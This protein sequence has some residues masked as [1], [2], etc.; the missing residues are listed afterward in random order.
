MPWK[1]LE[2][3]RRAEADFHNLLGPFT[4]CFL[5]AVVLGSA[6]SVAIL[7]SATRL[8]CLTHRRCARYQLDGSRWAAQAA[9]AAL[10]ALSLLIVLFQLNGRIAG[11]GLALIDGPTAPFEWFS[12]GAAAGAWAL[13]TALFAVEAANGYA[14]ARTWLWRFPVFLTLAAELAK[15]RFVVAFT[16]AH[17]YFFSLFAVSLIA[18]VALAA[19]ALLHAP[20]KDSL[21]LLDPGEA[22]DGAEGYLPLTEDHLR[23]CPEATA[24]LWSSL[25][26]SWMGALMRA[27]FAAPLQFSDIWALP[28]R[29][30][31]E[32]LDQKFRWE[33]GQE[34]VHQRRK[35]PSLVSHTFCVTL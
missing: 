1:T 24:G 15:L 35:Q 17:G 25:T 29:D 31:V 4:P 2:P 32:H 8:H 5:D 13:L 10:A 23:V 19:I 27:G 12:A 26:F 18:H 21:Q 11:G 22:A 14:P 16:P 33:W 7:L 3:C 28:P 9:A 34:L 20:S 30:R 6:Y